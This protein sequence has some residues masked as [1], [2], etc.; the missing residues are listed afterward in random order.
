MRILR[1]FFP[2]LKF[3]VSTQ[4]GCGSTA[5]SEV[6]A[7]LGADRVILERHLEFS[8]VR[9]IVSTAPVGIEIFVHGAMCY[10]YSGKCFFSSFLGGK[11]A[12]RGACVQPCRRLYGHPGGRGGGFFHARPFPDRPVAGARSAGVRRVQDRGADAKRRVCKRCRIRLPAGPRPDPRRQEGR[13]CR[14]GKG[15]SGESDRPR[16]DA[17]PHGRRR[18]LRGRCRRNDGKRGRAAGCGP[19]GPGGVGARR[20]GGEHRAGGPASRAVSERRL[21]KGVFRPVDA[22]GRGGALRPD[23][24]RRVAGRP[25]VPR[26]RRGTGGD[27]PFGP[28][29]TGGAASRRGSFPGRRGRW[30]PGRRG[31]VRQ[32]AR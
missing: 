16:G 26:R 27:Y 2:A 5:A 3:H 19:G 23:T 1:D 7:A 24:V 28:A 30:G 8:E 11:S 31:V 4:A 17:R 20:S 9:R 12:N 15:T 10:S 18:P 25:S 32:D 14:G 13:G 21:R 22:C 29:G 6:F